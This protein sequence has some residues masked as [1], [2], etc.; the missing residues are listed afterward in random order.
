MGGAEITDQSLLEAWVAQG[1]SATAVYVG[2][3]GPQAWQGVTLAPVANAEAMR[4][5][6][7]AARP[8]LIYSQIG[9]HALGLELARALG[10]PVMTCLHDMRPLCP[11]PVALV[12]CNRHCDYCP[13]HWAEAA[14]LER[15]KALLRQFDLIYT[16]SQFMADLATQVLGRADV[17]VLYPTIHPPVLPEGA[18]GMAIAM[19]TAERIKGAGLFLKIAEAM[20]EMTFLLAG[21]GDAAACGYDSRRH[22]NVQVTGMIAPSDFYGQSW[23]V[24][25]PSQWAEPF[26]RMAPEAQAAGVLCMGS[27]VGGIPEAMGDGGLLVTDFLDPE[28]WVK[29]IRVLQ[30]DPDL[31][32]IQRERGKHAWQRFEASKVEAQFVASVG[33]LVAGATK[34][35]ASPFVPEPAVPALYQVGKGMGRFFYG[36]LGAACFASILVRAGAPWLLLLPPLACLWIALLV[37]WGFHGGPLLRAKTRDAGHTGRQLTRMAGLLLVGSPLL[38][39]RGGTARTWGILALLILLS[40]AA[41]QHRRDALRVRG[42]A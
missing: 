12:N 10:V 15:S 3:H 38:L 29:A 28:A 34:S 32:R 42:G 20:P 11:A 19:S 18:R 31:Q 1:G 4:G 39:L 7:L 13:H 36:A 22:R 8:D 9:T 40:L 25:M 35:S 21:R 24:L 26:G 41:T 5:A 37:I 30:A 23:L 2:A 27:R 6:V 14:S 16:P 33:K 17:E